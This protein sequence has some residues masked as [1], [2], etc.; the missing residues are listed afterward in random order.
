MDRRIAQ[1]LTLAPFSVIVALAQPVIGSL[2]A[3]NAA[4]YRT[5]GLPGSGIA[6]GSIFTVFGTGLGPATS[7]EASSFPL[8][9]SLGGTSL[10]IS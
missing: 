1:L 6:Q 3:F 9:I 4:S 5:P 2:G 7:L 10:A 8:P